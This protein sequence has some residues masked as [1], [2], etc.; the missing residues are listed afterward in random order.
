[1]TRTLAVLA[2]PIALTGCDTLIDTYEGLTNPLVA[3]GLVLGIAA[4]D[5]DQ[6]DLSQTAYGEGTAI[7]VFLADAESADKLEEAPVEGADVSVRGDAFGDV[8]VGEAGGGTYVLEPGQV[9]Y[10]DGAVWTVVV[11]VAGE[12]GR[13]NVELPPPAAF[14]IPQEHTKGEP[15]DLDFTGKGF[16]AALIVVL[17]VES[18]NVTYSTEP[19]D[20]RDVYDLTRGNTELG[21]VQVPGTA[22][23]EDKV[24][25]LG[26]AGMVHT[27]AD[28]LESMNT[29][30]SS[31][32]AGK[33][34]FYPVI[35]AQLP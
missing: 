25:A 35:T 4:P 34:K 15:I 20:I 16:T 28:D 12:V 21:A 30:L 14:T 29:A 24:Y 7:T 13:A 33:M 10:A 11:D 18:G 5:S 1:M 19:K 3:Q 17:D 27:Q 6:I 23:P 8:A 2:L 31:V 9:T 26:V 32:L 22:F